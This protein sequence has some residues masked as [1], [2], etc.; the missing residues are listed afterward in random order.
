V[1]DLPAYRSGKTPADIARAGVPEALARL[2]SNESPFGPLPGVL[3]VIERELTTINRYPEVR[4]GTLRARLANW[5]DVGPEWVAIGPGSAGLLWQTAQVFLD[6]AD[7]IIVPWP[8]FEAYPIVSGLMGAELVTVPLRSETADVDSLI[9]AI[10]AR[11]K[12]LVIAEPNNPT[13]TAVGMSSIER[14]AEAT[15]GRCM[16]VVDEAYLEF[17]PESD[18]HR[19]V[20]LVREFDHVVVLRTFSKAH[21]L[22]GLRVGYAVAQPRAID[23]ID[24]VAPPFSV[25]SI[26][27]RAAIASLDSIEEV[28]TRVASTVRE[29]DRV[30]EALRSHGI[31][32]PPSSTNFVWVPGGEEIA[33]WSREL[34]AHGVIARPIAGA[35]IR[36]TVGEPDENQRV[37]EAL[38]HG[39]TTPGGI[40]T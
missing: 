11:T 6:E 14:L 2:A 26:A 31:H 1:L 34:E 27:Q 20:R 18:I 12:L 28:R 9:R 22:A 19:S 15:R 33:G 39:R 8:S 21:G 24:R 4:G 29:R 5:L 37:I 32:V 40:Q 13:G 38:A 35:G 36:I 16:L 25:S 23:L 10:T 3:D 7:Q 17:A 30:I